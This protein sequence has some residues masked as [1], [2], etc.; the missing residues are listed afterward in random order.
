MGAQ[1]WE[2]VT[3]SQCG[4]V[5]TPPQP[6]SLC[7]ETMVG[8][9]CDHRGAGTDGALRRLAHIPM[10]QGDTNSGGC[11]WPGSRARVTSLLC[12]LLPGHLR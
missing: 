6:G 7:G 12:S 2:L 10:T 3:W 8:P 4:S 11:P 5:W 9:A 1:G